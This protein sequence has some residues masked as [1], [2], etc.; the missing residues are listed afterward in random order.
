[1]VWTMQQM[2]TVQGKF[3]AELRQLDL[4]LPFLYDWLQL[5]KDM[6]RERVTRKEGKQC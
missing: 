2:G 5:H 3:W 4:C 6:S 1:M